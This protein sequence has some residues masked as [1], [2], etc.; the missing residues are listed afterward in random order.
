MRIL[1][2]TG[3]HVRWHRVAPWIVRRLP[4]IVRDQ[5]TRIRALRRG[6]MV[7][8]G[9]RVRAGAPLRAD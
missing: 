9:G 1:R 3:R 4:S 8:Y 2:F 7:V 6:R 5:A